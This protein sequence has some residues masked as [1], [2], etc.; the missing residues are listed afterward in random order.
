MT[1]A[2]DTTAELLAGSRPL[3]RDEPE[4]ELRTLLA[5]AWELTNAG[6][7]ATAMLLLE[8]A[9]AVS[10]QARF[11]DA[12]RA[13]VVFQL[14]CCRFKLGLVPNAVQ[15]F[16]AT[17]DLC[18]R[19]GEPADRLRVDA[20]RWRTRCYRRQREWEAARADADAAL[21]LAE[22][23][24]EAGV[25]ADA[26]LQASAVAERTGQLLVARFYVE[27]AVELFRHAGRLLD[28]GKALNNLGGILFLLDCPDEAKER[29]SQA[30]AIALELGDEVDAGYA[31]SSTA[32]VLV[33]GGNAVEGEH[34]ARHALTLL[35]DR[36]DHVNEIGNAQLV[37]GRALLEQ[38]RFDEAEETLAAA[39]ASVRQ[40][41]SVGHRAA[42][43]LVQGDLAARRGDLETAATVYRRAADALQDVRF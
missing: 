9:R 39:D 23:L 30:F 13:R 36:P 38:G 17:L 42:V 12:D 31:V 35:G 5:E 4:T 2:A 19:S 28:A 7:V 29:L 27:R 32:Q 21:E 33:R 26:Y 20:L 15:L 3:L 34:A 25:L 14:G 18:D 43:W 10:E 1:V 16:T 24:G 41:D 22:H 40:M 11:S 8:R 6:E 37:L